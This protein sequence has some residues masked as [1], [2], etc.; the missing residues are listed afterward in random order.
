MNLLSKLPFLTSNTDDETTLSEEEIRKQNIEF[1]RTKVRNGPAKFS[2]PTSGQM[3]RAAQRRLN[4]QTKKARRAQVRSH[5]DREQGIA[6][7][8]GNLQAAGLVPYRTP[9]F[10]ARPEAAL[11]SIVWIMQHYAIH[12]ADENGVVEVNHDV[13]MAALESALGRYNELVGTN[14]EIFEDYLLPVAVPA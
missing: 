6:Y 3:R 7:L 11:S 8:R 2:S 1:H 10:Q 14:Y 12:D 4:S 9:G 5:F 13:V